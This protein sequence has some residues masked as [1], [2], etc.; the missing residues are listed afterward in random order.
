MIAIKNHEVGMMRILI[1]FVAL[2]LGVLVAMYDIGPIRSL[3]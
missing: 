3:R 1:F 2:V